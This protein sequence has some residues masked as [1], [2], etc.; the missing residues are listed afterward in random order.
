MEF[1]LSRF[2]LVL[3]TLTAFGTASAT[4]ADPALQSVLARLDESAAKFRSFSA[5]MQ[6]LTHTDVINSDDIDRGT[7]KLKRTGSRSDLKMLIEITE[8]DPKAVAVQGKKGELYYPKMQ[9]VQ[10]YDLG[11]FREWLDQFYL[12]GFGTTS[13]ELQDGYSV[14]LLGSDTKDGQ[15]VTGLELIP[16][17]KEILEH[18]KKFELWLSDETGLPVEQKIYPAGQ[19]VVITYSNAKPNPDLPD[20]ALKLQLPKGTKREFPQKAGLK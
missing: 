10:E 7:I 8:P 2:A 11:K 5:N 6:R 16:K 19:Y 13:K 9:T 20:S 1:M 4:A 12:M 18:I 3:L 14:R 17:S 15:K